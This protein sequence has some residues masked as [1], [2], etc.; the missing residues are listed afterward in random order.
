M[1]QPKSE[2]DTRSEIWIKFEHKNVLFQALNSGLN[3]FKII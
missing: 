3:K 2:P 1:G